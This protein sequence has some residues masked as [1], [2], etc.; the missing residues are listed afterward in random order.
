MVK[1]TKKK[2]TDESL[3]GSMF[4]LIC[5]H[6]IGL[7]V[8]LLLLLFLSHLMFPRIRWRTQKFFH[9]S[10]YNEESGMYTS[11]IDDL[12]YVAFWIVVFTGLRASVM[13]YILHPLASLGGINRPRDVVRFVEQAWLIVYYSVIWP[14]GMYI[15]YNSSYWFNLREMWTNWPIAQMDGLFKWYYLV[16]FAFWLQQILVVNI[17][18]RR[19]DYAQYLAHHIITSA[20]MFMSYGYYQMRV[21]TVILSCMDVVDII[22]SAA[23]MLKY[24]GFDGICDYIFGL[25]MA[26]WVVARHGFYLSICWSL[27]AHTPTSLPSACYNSD[28]GVMLAPSEPGY[29]KNGGTEIWKNIL[30][31]YIDPHGPV[32]WNSNI[33]WSFM[34]LLLA[35]QFIT[36]LWFA[37]IVK[38]AWKVVNGGVADD[39]RSDDE[40]DDEEEIEV[41]EYSDHPKSSIP[42]PSKAKANMVMEGVPL[43][44]EVGVES[45]TFVR[46]NSPGVLNYKRSSAGRGGGNR[47]SGISIP[48]HGDRKELLGRIGCDKP[49]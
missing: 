38:V 11:G 21:G 40:G 22:L 47:S 26:T 8:N 6:Q 42:S 20:L 19:K 25:F 39:V 17:E 46:R 37:L 45:L 36:L 27:Y 43:E 15:V 48:G 9:L 32:C 29:E 3:L 14:M 49:T 2:P 44:E 41:E 30:Q 31:T 24:L 7:S 12:S 5:E 18:E 1:R 13:D 16:Q 28:T 35:L 10:Y 23:K 4:S 34:G 33:E